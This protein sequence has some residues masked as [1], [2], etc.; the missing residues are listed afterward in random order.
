M[1]DIDNIINSFINDIYKVRDTS[2]SA[3]TP[4]EPISFIINGKYEITLSDNS[5]K[6]PLWK[7]WKEQE[8]NL[9]ITLHNHYPDKDYE[10]SKEQF[11]KIFDEIS[12]QYGD[13]SKYLLIKII[14]YPLWNEYLIE[15]GLDRDATPDWEKHKENEK[16]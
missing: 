12:L 13:K 11:G 4:Y 1:T 15:R 5:E 6:V 10:L 9:V 16:S 8:H 3:E 14:E 2:E 7:F